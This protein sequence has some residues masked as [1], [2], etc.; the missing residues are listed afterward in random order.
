VDAFLI[1]GGHEKLGGFRRS[2]QHDVQIDAL[3]ILSRRSA[4]VSHPRVFL[5]R[6]L[7]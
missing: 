5:G 1:V 6:E 2:S 3:R 7:S 4:D